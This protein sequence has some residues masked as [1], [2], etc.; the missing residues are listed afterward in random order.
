MPVPANW[1]LPARSPVLNR[2]LLVDADG[3]PIEIG[4]S[5]VLMPAIEAEE[6]ANPCAS[7]ADAPG[8][9]TEGTLVSWPTCTVLRRAVGAS[10]GGVPRAGG[11]E[12]VARTLGGVEDP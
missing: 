7:L 10:N 2:L 8:T 4:E 3:L 9:R 1:L 11:P 5:A 12:I 6:D